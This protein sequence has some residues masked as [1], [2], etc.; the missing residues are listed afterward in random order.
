MKNNKGFTLIEIAMAMMI[1]AL[2]IGA[3]MVGRNLVDSS[4]NVKVVKEFTNYQQAVSTFYDI[5]T[6]LPGDMATAS[7]VWGGTNGNGNEQIEEDF[8]L[9]GGGESTH[10]WNHLDFEGLI[11]NVQSHS[12]GPTGLEYYIGNIVTSVVDS[13][14]Y[15]FDYVASFGNFMELGAFAVALTAPNAAVINPAEAFF[16]D[17]KL[18]D[19]LSTQGRVRSN[20]AGCRNGNEYLLTSEQNVCTL[21]MKLETDF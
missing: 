1:I 11:E 17:N 10:A 5:H 3:V 15:Y 16:I 7:S 12:F 6:A 14:V 4:R 9:S 13:G 19:G 20:L 2:I 21:R 8:A 18:D